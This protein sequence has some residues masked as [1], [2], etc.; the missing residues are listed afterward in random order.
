MIIKGRHVTYQAEI[1]PLKCRLVGIG[2]YGRYYVIRLDSVLDEYQI[3]LSHKFELMTGN[4]LV[5]PT[6]QSHHKAVMNVREKLMARLTLNK[7]AMLQY[8]P[9]NES[10]E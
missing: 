6:V 4:C 10:L 9:K 1:S 3:G 2:S 8:C 5:G 7:L